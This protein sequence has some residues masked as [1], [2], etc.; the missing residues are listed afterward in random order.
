MLNKIK[1]LAKKGESFAAAYVLDAR[2]SDL[3]YQRG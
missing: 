3:D 1:E 2:T